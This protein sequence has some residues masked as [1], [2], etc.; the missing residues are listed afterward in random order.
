MMTTSSETK[1]RT[2]LRQEPAL[3]DVLSDPIVRRVMDRDGVHAAEISDLA[4][5]YRRRAGN[6][7][8]VGE[9]A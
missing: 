8:G 1:W 9:A 2:A 4:K 6:A 7:G 3:T 5:A